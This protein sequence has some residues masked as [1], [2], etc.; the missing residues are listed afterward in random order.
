MT[1]VDTTRIVVGWMVG[2]NLSWVVLAVWTV[3]ALVYGLIRSRGNAPQDP[4]RP[5]GPVM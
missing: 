4:I 2:T 3:V 1:M 5:S